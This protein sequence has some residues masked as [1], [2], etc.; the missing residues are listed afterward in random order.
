MLSFVGY[1]NSLVI[2]AGI[3]QNLPGQIFSQSEVRQASDNTVCNI[4]KERPA[5]IEKRTESVRILQ[6]LTEIHGKLKEASYLK[7]KE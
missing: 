2:Q 4:A 1:V 3:L 6:T 5:R 7:H